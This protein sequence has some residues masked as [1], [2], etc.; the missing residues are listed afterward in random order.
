MAKT[1][2]G[3]GR[4]GSGGMTLAESRG[5]TADLNARSARRSSQGLTGANTRQR[6]ARRAALAARRGDYANYRRMMQRAQAI[7]WD[8]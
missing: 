3:A 2:G 5:I 6:Y 4:A 7:R 1:G 8:M